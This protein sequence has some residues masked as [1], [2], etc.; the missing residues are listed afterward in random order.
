MAAANKAN[1]ANESLLTQSKLKKI[2]RY[3]EKTGLFVRIF[4]CGRSI[5]PKKAGFAISIYISIYV[6]S[7]TYKAHRLAWLYVY[8][9]WPDGEIDHINHIRN[10][11]RIENLRVVT[12]Q[13][14]SRNRAISK[15]NSSGFTGVHIDKRTQRWQ[16]RIRVN[17]AL[18]NLGFFKC[19]AEAENKRKEANI[20]YGFHENHG[21]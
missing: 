7:R 3:N 15:A 18:I 11:N 20:L 1:K 19:R 13:E 16:A 10:D 14:N 12:S 21:K 2:L 8:G 5:S 9:Y 4:S 6:N 17:G